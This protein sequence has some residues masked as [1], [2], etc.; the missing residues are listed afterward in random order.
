MAQRVRAEFA[1]VSFS[2]FQ[3]S[4]NHITVPVPAFRKMLAT[5]RLRGRRA[6]SLTDDY[7]FDASND[8]GRWEGIEDFRW[9]LDQDYR[10][11]HRPWLL[12]LDPESRVLHYCWHS[13]EAYEMV[14]A[15]KVPVRREEP[16]PGVD[17]F[18]LHT[19][20]DSLGRV[21]FTLKW[22]GY[23]PSL[24]YEGCRGQCFHARPGE[25]IARSRA[26]GRKVKIIP[27]QG[28]RYER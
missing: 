27:D 26:V 16:S 22:W 11:G 20:P 8:N 25:Y 17:V 3:H 15:T 4:D 24:G 21:S 10:W 18:H 9:L 5:G 7:A 28:V 14:E 6:Y 23:N 12:Q 2:G 19:N 1:G 13:N